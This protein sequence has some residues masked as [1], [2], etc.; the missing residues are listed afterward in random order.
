MSH[1]ESMPD[2]RIA[3]ELPVPVPDLN[4]MQTAYQSLIAA[5]GESLTREGLVE[6]P[7]RAAKAWVHLTSGYRQTLEDVVSDAVFTSSNR[8]L[9]MVRDIEFYSLCEHHLLPFFGRVH[10]GYLP[11]GRVL[12][13]SK[14]ARVTDLFARRLQIQENMTEQIAQ[15][16]QTATGAR[17]VA[18]VIE[19]QHLCMMMRG[20]T[21]QHTDTRTV[22]MLGAMTTDTAARQE[23]FA[24]LR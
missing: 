4:V 7:E 19:A 10:I 15:A 3:E 11:E 21:K 2:L 14:M 22:A 20:V 12:G 9:V 18:V 23:F 6:T 13:L 16:V 24:A 8:E 17:G 1:L 5:A